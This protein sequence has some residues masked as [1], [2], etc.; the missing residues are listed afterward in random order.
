MI[1][2]GIIDRGYVIVVIGNLCL[3]ISDIVVVTGNLPLQVRVM[4]MSRTG[5]MSLDLDGQPRH[6]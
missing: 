6:Q 4:R 5:D 3:Q 2:Q 1:G